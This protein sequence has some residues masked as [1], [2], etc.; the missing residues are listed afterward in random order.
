MTAT[1]PL[2]PDLAFL[3]ALA[4]FL[5]C[6]HHALR[7]DRPLFLAPRNPGYA[8]LGRVTAE[9]VRLALGQPGVVLVDARPASAF[10][11]GTIATSYSLPLHGRIE[12][13]A[14]QTLRSARRVIVFCSSATCNASKELG[15]S[16][17]QR[18]VKVVEVYPGGF[19]QW[20]RLGY[21]VEAGLAR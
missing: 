17:L 1:R 3:L 10:A 2:R 19:E 7:A 4:G 18:G 6:L 16:L 21:P 11:R 20:Q 13:S 5:A 14:L 8:S 15:V 9:Q 12:E